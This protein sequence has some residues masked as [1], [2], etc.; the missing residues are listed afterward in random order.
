LTDDRSVLSQSHQRQIKALQESNQQFAVQ[1]KQTQVI[2]HVRNPCTTDAHR[3]GVQALVSTLQAKRTALQDEI[4]A[5]EARFEAMRSEKLSALSR[6]SAAVSSHE[7]GRLVESI[8][9]DH[10]AQ[11]GSLQK[12][13]DVL[14]SE[15]KQLHTELQL[16]QAEL[17]R[18]CSTSRNL[19]HALADERVQLRADAGARIQALVDERETDAR[20]RNE[21]RRV[22][23]ELQATVERVCVCCLPF[24]R[25]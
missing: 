14:A 4:A 11:S 23:S 18:V 13:I 3:D 19:V 5:Y 10:K 15:N 16:A 6:A 8:Q 25:D 22:L 24:G 17:E 20:Q 21:S 1:L 2:L 9:A 7:L 12:R